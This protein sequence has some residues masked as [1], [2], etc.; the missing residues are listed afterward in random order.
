M[1]GAL[2]GGEVGAGVGSCASCVLNFSKRLPYRARGVSSDTFLTTV[3]VVLE[4]VFSRMVSFIGRD[5]SRCKD[6]TEVVI[7]SGD[8]RRG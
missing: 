6:M 8:Y 3:L 7:R 5:R 2:F 1:R 4:T